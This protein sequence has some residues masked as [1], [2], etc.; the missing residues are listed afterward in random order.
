MTVTTFDPTEGRSD[1][2]LAAEA[3]ALAQGEQLAA[4]EE[5]DR[6]ARMDELARTTEEVELIGGKFKSQ[7]ELLKAYKALESKLGKKPQEEEEEAAEEPTEATEE[8]PAPESESDE[9]PFAQA[10]KEYQEG[11]KLSDAAIERL[12]QMDTKELIK[13]YVEFY[14][15]NAQQFQQQQALAQAEQAQ[16]MEIAGGEKRYQEVVGWAAANLDQSE[17]AAYNQVTA[18]GNLPAIKFA[19]EALVNRYKTAEGSE[20]PLVSGK[21]SV[22]SSGPK[23]YR[24]QA[25]LARDIANPKYEKDPAFRSDVMARLAKSS[26]LL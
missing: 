1:A 17:I 3:A 4:A 8:A 26:E 16:V 19:V 24:S 15:K 7:E 23:P 10:A 5:A 2:D 18:S 22:A 6:R 25:E 14:S 21:K 11:G 13:N 12:S 20:A 9:D